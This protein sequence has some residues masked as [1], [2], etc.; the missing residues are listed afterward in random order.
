MKRLIAVMMALLLL[1]TGCTLAQGEEAPMVLT[2]IN[3]GKADCLLLEYDGCL[4][5]IDTGTDDSW[6]RVSAALRERGVTHLD[7]VIVTHADGDHAGGVS[8]LASSSIAV[9]V[10]YTS[11]YCE[12][13]KESKNPVL[14]AAAM[15]GAQVVR[16]KSGDTLPFGS[17]RLTALGPMQAAEEENNDSVVLLAEGAGGFML[18]AGDME[19]DEED[20]LLDAGL[21]PACTVLKVGNHGENDASSPTLIQTVRPQIAVISTSTWEEP[22]T[23]SNR[24]LKT[25]ASVGA[26]VYITQDAPG[27]VQVVLRG[28]EASV[29]MLPRGQWPE[30]PTGLRLTGKDNKADVVSVVN[31]GAVAVDLSGCYLRSE[32]GGEIFVFPDGALIQPGQTIT[33]TTLSSARRGDYQWLESNVW[34]DKKADGAKLYDAYGR[35]L[36]SAD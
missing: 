7:G 30:A 36:A 13:Y 3:V 11:A 6:G 15:R 2:A 34:H 1:L 12:K 28:G 16:L 9:D 29:D 25:L 22:D 26:K 20:Q 19:Y 23:P 31:D 10:W 33:V 21:I 4:Y 18:L 35:E 27:A 17:G 24:V 5:M 14:K 8:A 32:K